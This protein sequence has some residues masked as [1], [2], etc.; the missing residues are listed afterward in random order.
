MAK[1]Y[2]RKKTK[3][4]NGTKVKYLPQQE[5]DLFSRPDQNVKMEVDGEEP[6]VPPTQSTKPPTQTTGKSGPP[7]AK[8]VKK[9]EEE[10]AD[11]AGL[12]VKKGSTGR[13]QRPRHTGAKIRARDKGKLVREQQITKIAKRKKRLAALGV[14]A[15]K[16]K[17][18]NNNDGTVKQV[19]RKENDS[20]EFDKMVAAYKSKISAKL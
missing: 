15:V 8:K 18:K 11:Y 2:G 12:E 7:K 10:K 19:K 13:L 1:S 16:K 14:T 3:E 17:I 4:A 9:N 20:G 6:R 5:N